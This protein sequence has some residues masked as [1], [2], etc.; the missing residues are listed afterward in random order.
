[1]KSQHG[2]GNKKHS[3]SNQKS[4]MDSQLSQFA[5]WHPFTMTVAA[6][7]GGGEDMVCQKST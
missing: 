3:Y 2:G 7:T 6:S 5:L 4:E 1:M